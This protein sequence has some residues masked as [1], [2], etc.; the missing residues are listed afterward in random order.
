MVETPGM[1][2][3]LGACEMAGPSFHQTVPLGA[4]F[5]CR[6]CGSALVP[7]M[8]Q[9]AL[10]VAG[11]SA[12]R[13]ALLMGTALLMLG[14]A[15]M[16][17]R[18]LGGA[19]AP[20]VPA[21]RA[22]KQ[23]AAAQPVAS[24]AQASN[25]PV[26]APDTKDHAAQ[27]VAPQ[28]EAAQPQLGAVE[29]N[30]AAA[31]PQHSIA[32]TGPEPAQT[33]VLAPPATA[34]SLSPVQP[35]VPAAAPIGHAEAA[36]AQAAATAASP[37]APASVPALASAV[38]SAVDL[39]PRVAAQ[40]PADQLALLAP[41][42]ALASVAPSAPAQP[43]LQNSS[44]PPILPPASA[45]LP[46][47]QPFSP[48]AISGGAPAY[49]AEYAADGR[50]GRVLVSC[51]IQPDGAPQ[52]CRASGQKAGQPFTTAALAWLARSKVRFHPIILHGH[53]VAE[54]RSWP[55]VI[56]E[57]PAL[58]A[59]A[60]RKAHEAEAARDEATSPPAITAP[61]LVRP[62][63]ATMQMPSPV[64]ASAEPMPKVQPVVSRVPAPPLAR[65]GLSDRPFSTRVVRG[66]APEYPKAYDEARPGS[67][68]VRCTIQADGS[69]SGC[70]ILQQTGGYAFGT[71]VRNWLG[72]G[73]VR[74]DPMIEN[75]QPVSRT[76][77]W[78]VV[79]NPDQDR[80]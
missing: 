38:P 27:A 40:K 43:A 10:P 17:G 41:A 13:P 6:S 74:F 72:S 45:P 7:P 50:P 16:L 49:P 68:T 52:G 75:G 56:E 62:V 9:T 66:G 42:S 18:E 23:L 15:L 2:T 5:V 33:A 36:S 48:V 76:E 58:L 46:P 53:A 39:S 63:L 25:A 4:P 32:T 12:L 22:P 11:P 61:T 77:T 55:L 73:R 3:K 35:S 70:N 44:P 20:A 79:F 19:G 29:P 69:P 24:P 47:D 21:P 31:A 57:S 65:T 59:D 60:R 64:S 71:S 37:V 8:Q 80:R 54:A 1:C 78:T 28:A 14:G 26:A 30:Q 51:T 67:V 34:V